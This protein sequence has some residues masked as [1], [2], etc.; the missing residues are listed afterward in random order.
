[1][2]YLYAFI[3]LIGSFALSS[4]T[5]SE[6]READCFRGDP[7]WETI[8]LESE[9]CGNITIDG[10]SLWEG[11]ICVGYCYTFS[12]DNCRTITIEGIT[13]PNGMFGSN[14]KVNHNY[15]DQVQQTRGE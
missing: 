13:P 12:S 15:Y 8:H 5:Y 3:F 14:K 4:Y 2:R 9:R 1:M 7:V 6:V 10:W 11:D